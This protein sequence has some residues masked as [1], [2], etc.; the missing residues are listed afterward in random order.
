MHIRSSPKESLDTWLLSSNYLCPRDAFS[1][2]SKVKVLAASKGSGKLSRTPQKQEKIKDQQVSWLQTT[3][4]IC[5]YGL[6]LLPDLG[7]L[8]ESNRF[9]A[10]YTHREGRRF[11]L[12]WV[13]TAWRWIFSGSWCRDSVSLYVNANQVW[14]WLAHSPWKSRAC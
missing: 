4:V 2:G 13:G 10:F 11:Y 8:T 7:A 3:P 14:L 12:T 5:Y 6:W 9:Q 1:P